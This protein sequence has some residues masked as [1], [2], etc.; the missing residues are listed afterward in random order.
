MDGGI[1]ILIRE[2]HISKGTE[3]QPEKYVGGWLPTR[4]LSWLQC[5]T[6]PL[7]LKGDLCQL[8]SI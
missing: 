7:A 6:V 8:H 5:Q 3:A 4:M 2:F 1:N